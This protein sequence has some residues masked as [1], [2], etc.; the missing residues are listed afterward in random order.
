LQ[1]SSFL[2][3]SVNSGPERSFTEGPRLAQSEDD[4]T[5]HTCLQQAKLPRTGAAKIAET[6][7]NFQAS[8]EERTIEKIAEFAYL[9]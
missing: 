4:N 8:N 6:F 9:P 1:Q 2:K 5:P 3:G 7:R